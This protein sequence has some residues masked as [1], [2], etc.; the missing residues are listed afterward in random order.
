MHMAGL[1]PYTYRQF[2]VFSPT[3]F[4]CHPH[5]IRTIS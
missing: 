4:L 2:S 5:L 3:T 1:F